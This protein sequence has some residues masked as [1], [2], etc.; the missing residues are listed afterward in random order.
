MEYVTIS[1]NADILYTLPRFTTLVI[2]GPG[3]VR[4]EAERMLN[5][6]AAIGRVEFIGMDDIRT[7][8]LIE[9]ASKTRLTP[10]ELPCFHLL[11][12]PL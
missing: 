1:E 10:W 2:E 8:Q 12:P 7:L 3:R 11:D 5:H 9:E 6:L 4:P